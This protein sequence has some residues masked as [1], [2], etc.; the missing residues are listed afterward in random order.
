MNAAV[1]AVL[2]QKDLRRAWRNPIPY[3]IHLGLPL[4]LT[5]MLG[6]VFGSAGAGGGPPGK[7]RVAVVDEDDSAVT[8]MLR[9]ALGQPQAGERL[10]AKFLAR[11]QAFR[12]VTNGT[13][14]AALVLPRG[15]TEGFLTG[16]GSV[17]LELL[18]NP[19]QSIH[20]ALIEEAVGALATGLNAVARNF[21]TDLGE[22]RALVGTGTRPT[23]AAIAALVEKTVVRFDAARQRLSPLPV[24]YDTETAAAGAPT[25]GGGG[26]VRGRE[27]GFNLFA[28]LLP[29]LTAMFLLFLADVAMRDLQREVRGGTFERFCTLPTSALVFVMGK[30]GFV[31]SI[32]GLGAVILLGG[33]GLIFQFRWENPF[34]VATLAAAFALFAAGLMAALAGVVGGNRRAE[35]LNTLVA[36]AF[37]LA[38]GGAFPAESLPPFLRDHVTVHLPT[39][40]FI[41]ATRA[42]QQIGV[43]G[44]MTWPWTVAKLAALGLGLSVVAAALLRRRLMAGE[45]ATS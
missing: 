10:E 22:W 37:G 8:R 40:W 7:V 19:A 13:V 4:V 28:F 30:V 38:G 45:R 11:D 14:A 15:F 9:G 42:T 36:M 2:L 5:G 35:V 33:G 39:A 18:K 20:P 24:W 17:E 25:P 44:P 43:E 16:R 26:G 21:G 12:E 31:F 32:V 41:E 1:L 6:M 34:A 3:L 27:R 29:G 23:P